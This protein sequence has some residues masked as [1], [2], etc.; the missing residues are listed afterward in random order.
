MGKQGRVPG[1]FLNILL[2]VGLV[3]TWIAFAPVKLGGQ[4]SYV[5]VDGISMLPTFHTGDLVLVRK[6]PTYQVG[7]VVSYQD[8]LMG[9]AIIH[10][11]IDVQGDHFLLKGDNNLWIDEYQPSSTEIFGKEWIFLPKFGEAVL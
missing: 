11:I 10:R 7:D 8:A 4:V 6:A 3:A 5:L 1:V 2:A 9:A